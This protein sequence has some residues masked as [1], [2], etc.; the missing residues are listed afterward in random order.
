MDNLNNRYV[1]IYKIYLGLEVPHDEVMELYKDYWEV[2]PDSIVEDLIESLDGIKFI[3]N[4]YEKSF[5]KTFT[6]N[7]F[8]LMK[9]K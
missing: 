4:E 1:N 8:R 3:D 2:G 5:V 7:L 6:E 9:G